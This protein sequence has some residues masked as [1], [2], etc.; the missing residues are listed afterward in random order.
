MAR[1]DVSA[2][3]SGAGLAADVWTKLVKAVRERGGTDED[4]HRLATDDGGTVIAK[5]ADLIVEIGD[6]AKNVFRVTVDYGMSVEE[7][8][9]LGK[10]DSANP[11]INS[12]NFRTDRRGKTEVVIHVV[13][14]DRYISLDEAVRELDKM[15]LRPAELHELLAFGAAFP[16]KQRELPI[17]ALG[18]RRRSWDGPWDVPTL[19]GYSACRG[20]YL[21]WW[22]SGVYPNYR[23]AAVRK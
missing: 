8:V 6:Q 3:V 15:G 22:I 14:L 11:D 1:K 18:S 20:L 7:L 10:Y 2:I 16:D 17:T 23:F 13:P 4:I 21:D 12:Q 19:W 5:F 9:R